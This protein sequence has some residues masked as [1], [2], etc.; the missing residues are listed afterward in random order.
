MTQAVVA[1][2]VAAAAIIVGLV[3]RRRQR[4]D[5]P[6]QPRFEAPVQLDRAD[7][8]SPG[9]PWL[10]AVFTSATCATCQGALRHAK[11]LASA[12]GDVV[13]AEVEYRAA[14]DL[15]RKYSIDVVPIVAIADAAGVVATSFI[16]EVSADQLEG[17]MKAL[18]S[19][20]RPIERGRSMTDVLNQDGPA[21]R[22]K[23]EGVAWL[24][25]A[26]PSG[27]PQSS[28]VWFIWDGE[29]LWLR[30]QA[31][32]GKVRNIEGNPLVS[33][34]LADDGNGGNIITIEGAASIESE[35]PDLFQAYLA[36]YDE[37]IR[38]GLQTTPEQLAADYPTTIRIRPTRT[39]AW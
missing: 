24:T 7:F 16:G 32:A 39:R 6:T 20:P 37:P 35:P 12:D 15:H 29:S 26:G 25:T 5:A 31:T 36:K 22:L 38:T 33:F 3:L 19:A 23:G 1:V 14:S 10:V 17:A 34:H 28:P 11:Q 2:A 21:Q 8:P 4:A 9:T 30:S 27:Q 18:S 13:V